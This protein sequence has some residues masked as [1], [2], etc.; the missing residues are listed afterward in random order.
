MQEFKKS[1]AG[2]GWGVVGRGVT[3]DV[4]LRPG[5]GWG[6]P[7]LTGPD[8]TQTSSP[9]LFLYCG[10]CLRPGRGKSSHPHTP[11]LSPA[12]RGVIFSPQDRSIP[13]SCLWL[14]T[15]SMGTQAC[16]PPSP[17]LFLFWRQEGERV[18][19]G[20]P[21]G[22][23][24]SHSMVVTLELSITERLRWRELRQTTGG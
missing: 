11:C 22:A 24:L 5:G 13:P 7:V 12:L 6:E 8:R 14:L 19:D 16:C 18:W 17:D 2:R 21:S 20:T 23:F 9:R 1:W 4:S 10:L 15:P 3:R